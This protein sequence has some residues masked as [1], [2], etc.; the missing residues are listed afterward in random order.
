MLQG[1]KKKDLSMRAIINRFV[2]IC[3]EVVPIKEPIYEFGSFQVEGQE[4][5]A[6]LRPYFGGKRYIGADMRIGKGVDVILDLHNI[7][8]PDN[9]VGTVLCL[10]TL[11]HV[12]FPRRAISEI[13]RILSDDGIL[14]ISSVMNYRIHDHPSDYW[15]F[16]P[17]GFCSLLRMFSFV[18]VE[19]VGEPQFPHTVVGV[20]S[21]ININKEQEEELV[22]QISRWKREYSTGKVK[23][24]LKRMSPPIALDILRKLR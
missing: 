10:D 14:I 16:T 12:E 19:C 7:N 9:T 13:R 15:R 2:K 8:L 24:L 4:A 23:C 18:F 17:K 1:A 21:A 20:A 11:E 22:A 6:D 5:L 3:S